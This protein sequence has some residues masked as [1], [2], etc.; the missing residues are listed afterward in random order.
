MILQAA[1]LIGFCLDAK[2]IHT[3]YAILPELWK[4]RNMSYFA[5]GLKICNV[6]MM[7]TLKKV[8]NDFLFELCF[9]SVCFKIG[10]KLQLLERSWSYMN[11]NKV[12][13]TFRTT[14]KLVQ[15]KLFCIRNVINM[16]QKISFLCFVPMANITYAYICKCRKYIHSRV[17]HKLRLLQ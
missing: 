5:Y 6:E 12:G 2:W 15:I 14:K 1:Y 17:I 10:L 9:L 3:F 13:K 7:N 16:I 8:L 11:Y 4:L